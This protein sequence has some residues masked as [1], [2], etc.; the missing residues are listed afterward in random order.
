MPTVTTSDADKA[1]DQHIGQR[2]VLRRAALKM[3]QSTLAAALGVSFQQVQKY[4]SGT[5]RVAASRLYAMSRALGAPFAYW[6]EGYG[7]IT[8]RLAPDGFDARAIRL[9]V[10]ARHATPVEIDSISAMLRVLTAGR[11]KEAD[12][13]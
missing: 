12:R 4:E 3:N 9:S 8:P 5:N 6:A 10:A 11:G 2:I 1:F 7:D 13:G